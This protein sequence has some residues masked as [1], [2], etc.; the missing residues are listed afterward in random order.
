M[1]ACAVAL[2]DE[3]SFRTGTEEYLLRNGSHGLTTL[4]KRHVS[5]HRREATFDFIGKSGV[6][7]TQIVADDDIV[8]DLS[9]L[10]RRRGGGS[11]LLAFPDRDGWHEVRS[12]HVTRYLKDL[13]GEDA[14][15]KDFRTWHATVFA[16]F[17]LATDEHA[18]H[19][20]GRRMAASVAREVSELLGNTAAVARTAYI[21]PRVFQRFDEGVT[22]RD[23][24]PKLSPSSIDDR[25]HRA[26]I[27]AAVL[28]LLRGEAPPSAWP[29]D[30]PGAPR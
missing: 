14:S 22:I 26:Q 13:A 30:R 11:Q 24:I 9:S 18:M 12:A 3:G 8:R 17:L 28:G 2:L 19:V 27:E 5:L 6:R 4:R 21:D 20:S 16:A 29:P 10:L 23:F 7:F 1:L 25:G 15:A